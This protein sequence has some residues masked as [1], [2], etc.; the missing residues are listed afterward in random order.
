VLGPT[1]LVVEPDGTRGSCPLMDLLDPKV[2]LG[3]LG[4]SGLSVGL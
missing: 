3:A 2:Y 1:N 4:K